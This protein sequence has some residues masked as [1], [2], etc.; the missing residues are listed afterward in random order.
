MTVFLFRFRAYL[1]FYLVLPQ[2]VDCLLLS[3]NQL[4]ARLAFALCAVD[5]SVL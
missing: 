1:E 4:Y 3:L 2:V 5:I